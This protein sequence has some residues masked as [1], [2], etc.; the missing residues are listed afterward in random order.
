MLALVNRV[1]MSQGACMD[2]DIF[3]P[4]QYCDLV[5][6]YKLF[7]DDKEI[8][9]IK[10]GTNQTISLPNDTKFIQA[11]I[12]WCSSPKVYIDDLNSNKVIIRNSFA[13]NIITALLL[14]LYYMTF[15]KN[16]YLSI[17]NGL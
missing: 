16:R 7:A 15:G 4:K 2:I 10:R 6:D 1:V 5:R 12:D 9:M 14:S 11:K 13:G 17:E 8:A 3:R